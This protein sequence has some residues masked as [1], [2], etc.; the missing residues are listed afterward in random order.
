MNI[1]QNF[2]VLKKIANKRKNDAKN[3]KIKYDCKHTILVEDKGVKICIECGY[4]KPREITMNKEWRF[5]GSN[6]SRRTK[7]PN[8]CHI[9][10]IYKKTIQKE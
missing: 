9:R 5:Y 8:R 7:D 1:E 6:D 10:K 3:S 2:S 4:E